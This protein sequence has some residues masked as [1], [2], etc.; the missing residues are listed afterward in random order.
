MKREVL[1]IPAELMMMGEDKFNPLTSYSLL[2]CEKDFSNFRRG[3]FKVY[4]VMP[5]KPDYTEEQVQLIFHLKS[6]RKKWKEITE[7]YN[8]LH[9][10]M[11]TV[12]GLRSR[13]YKKGGSHIFMK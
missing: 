4:S 8:K 13:Y 6:K 2:T 1:N 9:H 5:P 7:I 12:D 3:Y 10:P 11:R